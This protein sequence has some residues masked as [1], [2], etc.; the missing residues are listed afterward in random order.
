MNTQEKIELFFK[1]FS[2]ML[3]E[4]NIRYGDSALNPNNIFSKQDAGNSILIRLD[5]KINRI[6]NSD[7]IRKND[8]LDMIGYLSLYCVSKDWLNMEEQID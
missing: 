8:I 2:F 6:Q 7:E 4:K 5:D 3:K 1:N